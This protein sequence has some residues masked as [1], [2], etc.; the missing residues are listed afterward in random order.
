MNQTLIDS[1]ND[2]MDHIA[3]YLKLEYD[4]VY[5]EKLMENYNSFFDFVASYYIGGNTIPETSRYVVELI[6]MK[7]KE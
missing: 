3:N 6:L 5:Y 7:A 1:I 2:F 4:L